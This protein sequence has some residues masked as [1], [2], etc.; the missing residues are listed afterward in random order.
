[1]IRTQ[2]CPTFCEI[3]AF[4]MISDVSFPGDSHA[5]RCAREQASGA[6]GGGGRGRQEGG[7]GGGASG[8]RRIHGARDRVMGGQKLCIEVA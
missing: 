8:Q 3:V 7:A 6:G 2:L 5:G 1:M 4:L